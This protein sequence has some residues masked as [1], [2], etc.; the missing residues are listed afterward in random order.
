MD[1]MPNNFRHIGLIRLMRPNARVI[2]ARRQPMSCGLS[3]FELFVAEG[4]EFSYSLED[5][6]RITVPI[7]S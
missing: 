5:I 3:V 4:Q 6:G 2:V 1:K 7:L